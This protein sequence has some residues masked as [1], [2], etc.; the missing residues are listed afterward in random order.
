MATRMPRT[1]RKITFR[2][3]AAK[4]RTPLVAAAIQ[5]VAGPHRKSRG[6]SAQP[7]GPGCSARCARRVSHV[8][9]ARSCA[10]AHDC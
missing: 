8:A 3:A 6:A 1:H 5:R 9:A 7:N 10:S 2:I 4:P